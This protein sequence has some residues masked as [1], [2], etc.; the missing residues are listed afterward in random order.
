MPVAA[1]FIVST[2]RLL[3]EAVEVVEVISNSPYVDVVYVVFDIVTFS[4]LANVKSES[5]V[6]M[7]PPS[8]V[9]AV[10]VVAPRPLT[11]AKVS[12]SE[13][14][15]ADV[16]TVISEPEVET[17]VPPEPLMVISPVPVVLMLVTISV[18]SREI[19]GF[20]PPV[21]ATPVPPVTP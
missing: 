19:D 1:V 20:W 14:K 5:V 2:S 8:K 9:K 16:E 15:P 12:A 17:V 7:K 18:E 13:V 10:P 6:V 21:T 11:V 4:V 3:V